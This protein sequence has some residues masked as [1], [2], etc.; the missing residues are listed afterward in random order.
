[1]FE[2][3]SHFFKET[4]KIN[5]RVVFQFGTVEP[6][7][8]YREEGGRIVCYGYAIH[9][10]QH[11]IET[12]RTDPT[13]LSSIGYDD[14]TEFTLKEFNE[15]SDGEPLYSIPKK[16]SGFFSRLFNL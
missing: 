2:K 5:Y 3:K 4:Q 7:T 12:H 10:D 8:F 13:K 9:R 11:G 14:G 16:K 15:L 1:M 6:K